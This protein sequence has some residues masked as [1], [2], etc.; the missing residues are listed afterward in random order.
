MDSSVHV[1]IPTQEEFGCNTQY[2]TFRFLLRR[3]DNIHVVNISYSVFVSEI[4]NADNSK[5]NFD[6]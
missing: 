2:F 1:V 5:I 3:N 6:L 4:C